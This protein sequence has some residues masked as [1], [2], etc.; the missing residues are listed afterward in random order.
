MNQLYLVMER[1]NFIYAGLGMLVCL[2]LGFVNVCDAQKHTGE[3]LM[4]LDSCIQQAL[5]ANYSIQIIRNKEVQA[6]NNVTAGP[7]LPKVTLQAAQDQ[8]ISNSR[9]ESNGVTNKQDWVRS[10]SL[11]AGVALNW[12]L[13]DGLE[14]FVTH[15]RYE[16]LMAIG[17]LNTKAA[18]ENLI[19]EV[20]SCYYEVVRRQNKVDAA[21]HSLDL[22]MLR[23]KEAYDK[24]VLGSLSGLEALQAKLDLNADSSTYMQERR[25]L[26]SAYITL[27]TVMNAD[28]HR[29]Q[30]VK[31]SIVLRMPLD[32]KE[33]EQNVLEYNT[34]L[35]IGRK[36]CKVSKLEMKLARAALFPK[37]NFQG[38]YNF[39][40][41]KSPAKVTTLNRSNGPYWGFSLSMNVF[42]RLENRRKIQNARLDME[43][44]ELTYQEAEL[45]VR[46]DLT[47]LFNTYTNN[48]LL[49][50]F[51]K[52]N[53][54]IA[55]EN[56]DAAMEKYKLGSLAGIEFREFQRSYIDAVDREV[57][58]LYDTKISELSLLLISGPIMR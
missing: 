41:T 11:S 49:V 28:L 12:T 45:Q 21:R 43:N 47:Q 32:F 26:K 5:R 51:E 8:S 19:V 2:L 34:T 37:L 38:G 6:K 36:D 17:E 33:L 27:N 46:S 1:K 16:E 18:I 14:M 3:T 35:Q 53:A 55:F 40:Q 58:A 29:Y 23:Y 54:R 9:T 10:N 15:D 13:F 56:L 22:S 4:T 7:F 42:N 44:S 25:A 57:S 20:A 48:L 30:Y 31:D 50:N 39:S 52:D 24:Y